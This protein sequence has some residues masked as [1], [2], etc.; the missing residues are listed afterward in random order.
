[1]TNQWVFSFLIFALSMSISPGPNNLMIMATAT[2][3][4]WRKTISQIL[5]VSLGFLSLLALAIFGV[6]EI[7]HR[8]PVVYTALKVMGIVYL[9]YLAFK[10]LKSAKTIE[11]PSLIKPYSFIE[12]FGFQFANPKGWMMA[13]STAATFFPA[14][15]SSVHFAVASGLLFTA[16]NLFS[17]S[18][19]AIFGVVLAQILNTPNKMR[20]FNWVVAMMLVLSIY[21]IV[22]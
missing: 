19:W 20:V 17:N 22:T 10:I 12:I 6:A 14:G 5:A 11:S 3:F 7:V 15:I 18:V 4:G 8:V 2:T 13:M 1:M 9:L 21:F 16:V